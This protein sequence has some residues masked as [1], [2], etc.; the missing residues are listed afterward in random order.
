M[1][2]SPIN[3]RGKRSR[4]GYPKQSYTS[5]RTRQ[6][7]GKAPSKAL[8]QQANH[9]EG[10]R[11]K[12]SLIEAKVPLEILC[13]IFMY[14]ENVNFALASGRIGKFLSDIQT[15]R[16][17]FIHAIAP[18]WL[19][20]KAGVVNSAVEGDSGPCMGNPEFQV[21]IHFVLFSSPY[22]SNQQQVG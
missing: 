22:P 12:T 18:R 10:N 5:A 21:S 1:E 16:E 13:K 20:D 8:G 4:S 2:L 7:L 19:N 9:V 6:A 15:R 17:V 3:V 14:S 11:V